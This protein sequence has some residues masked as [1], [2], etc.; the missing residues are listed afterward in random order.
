M[1]DLE[2]MTPQERAMFVAGQALFTHPEVAKEAKR[3]YKKVKP[4]ASFP[5]IELEDKIAALEKAN[6]EREEKLEEDLR[7]ERL[8]RK[9]AERHA[10]LRAKG[11]DPDTIDKFMVDNKIGDYDIAVK[12]WEREQQTA[13]PTAPGI[14]S[15][16]PNLKPEANLLKM[17]AGALKNWSAQEATKAI[18]EFRGRRTA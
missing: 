11:Y 13:E 10:Q 15:T 2:S 12:F 18:S 5:E 9:H 16:Q 8:E 1:A 17:G 7:R 6:K 4:E 3:L 14:I